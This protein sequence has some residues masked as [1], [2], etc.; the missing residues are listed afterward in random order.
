MSGDVFGNGML[1]SEQI[2]LVAAF[3]HRHVFIDPNPDPEASFAERK[4]L[5]ELPGSSWDDYDR[6]KISAGGGVWSRQEK[7]I[8][9]V[10][11]GT[12]GARRRASTR[13]RPN[14][15][16]S[17]I[18]R[19]PVDLFWN[20]GI[21][22]FV[23]ATRRDPRRRRRP[24]ERRDPGRRRRPAGAG[25]RRRA[26]ISGSRSAGR[27]EYADSGGRDQHRL[28]RQLGRRRLVRPRGQPEDPARHRGRRRGSDDRSS[29]TSCSTRSRQDVAAHVLY[30]NYLQAQILSQEVAVSSERIEAY[31]DLMATSRGGR[32]C[33]NARSR[34]CR[35]PRRW[36]SGPRRARQW[37]GPSSASCSPTQSAASSRRSAT[38]RSRTIR[39]STTR[40]AATSRRR[41]SSGSAT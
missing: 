14:E 1:L 16:L 21:G 30:D 7:S 33:W 26:A 35:R 17:A 29:A 4:R 28:H 8:P 40:C 22:T 6:S 39:S 15:V 13:P 24:R 11:G 20:G 3:D 32:G 27:I 36:P 19:A 25:R 12:G 31:E 34:P 41:S 5:F 38:P 2:R 18:L 23:K 9:L 37:H 10:A